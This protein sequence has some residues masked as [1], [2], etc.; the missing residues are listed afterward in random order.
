[1]DVDPIE[2]GSGQPSL[3]A[4]DGVLGTGTFPGRIAREAARTPVQ[5]TARPWNVCTQR[6]WAA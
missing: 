2:E 4:L 6:V 3:V 1:V 5:G